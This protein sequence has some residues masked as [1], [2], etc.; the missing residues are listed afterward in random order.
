MAACTAL[1]QAPEAR[2]QVV[3]GFADQF[4]HW[5][6]ARDAGQRR[7]SSREQY[8]MPPRETSWREPPEERSPGE[9]HIVERGETLF[10]ISK[11]YGVSVEA[12]MRENRIPDPR[13]LRVGQRLSIPEEASSRPRSPRLDRWHEDEPRF[14]APRPRDRLAPPRDEDF[15][16]RFREAPAAPEQR[17]ER[18]VR[19]EYR[20]TGPNPA[21]ISRLA[22]TMREPAGRGRDGEMPAGYTFFAQLVGADLQVDRML[23][24]WRQGGGARRVSAELDL[25]IIYGNGPEA[26]PERFYLP[27]VRTMC[28]LA[29]A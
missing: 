3:S 12:L 4:D 16:P 10:R 29:R 21:E 26:D 17:P 23:R 13:Q 25:D 15:D 18:R 27:Y 28:E 1:A 20:S 6:N 8:D 9:S 5:E 22:H 2:A 14:S 11:Q 19:S 24:A 7:A